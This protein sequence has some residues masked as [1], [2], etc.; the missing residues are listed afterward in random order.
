MVV[1][2]GLEGIHIIDLTDKYHLKHVS[3][4]PSIKGSV[5]SISLSHDNNFVFASCRDQGLQVYNVTEIQ[6]IYPVTL[7]YTYGGEGLYSSKVYTDIVYL[8]D[9]YNGLTIV[10]VSNPA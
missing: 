9:G 1:G 7:L 2:C 6:N 4:A 8:A 5:E 3:S 10:N